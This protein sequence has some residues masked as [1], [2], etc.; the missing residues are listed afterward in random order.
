MKL[1]LNFTHWNVSNRMSQR[2]GRIVQTEF[3]ISHRIL[4]QQQQI[5]YYAHSK[6]C[7][8][9]IR[10]RLKFEIMEILMN[11]KFYSA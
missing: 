9:T 4:Q 1:K 7:I 6:L 5:E 11:T 2:I 8:N 3:I 10:L